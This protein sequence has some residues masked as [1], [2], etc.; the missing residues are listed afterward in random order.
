M[1]GHL[2]HLIQEDL[3]GPHSEAP[4]PG[5]AAGVSKHRA[6]GALRTTNAAPPPV[7]TGSEQA[8]LPLSGAVSSPQFRYRTS[9]LPPKC[10]PLSAGRS[11][12]LV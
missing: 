4:A 1:T 3:G 12:E 5:A 8:R 9:L 2:Q 10:S 11:E 6:P 7:P